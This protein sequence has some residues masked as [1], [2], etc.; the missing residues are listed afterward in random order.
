MK[1]SGLHVLI[2]A[3]ALLSACG[4]DS[5]LPEATGKASISAIN[6]IY[7]SPA[8]DFLIEE[9][10]LA[11]VSYKGTH[12]V[13][14]YDD[15][16]Y[17]FNFDV[18]YA[19]DTQVTRVASQNLDLVA[20]QHYT[21]LASGALAAPTI[22]V[23]ET[24]ERTFDGTET[25]FQVRFAHTSDS[26]GAIDVYYALD[27]VVPVLGE[28]VGTLSFGEITAPMDFETESYVITMTTS[29]DPTDV[30]FQSAPALIFART[31]L[32]ITPFDG[33]ANDTSPIAVRGLNTGGG[34]IGFLDPLYPSTVEF[35]HAANDMGITDV[36]D[37]E[38]LT[39]QILTA[40]DFK[41][42]TPATPITAGDYRY[43]Y[44]PSGDTAT[45]L[46]DTAFS[47]LNGIH[48]RILATG[49]GGTYATANIPL[50]RRSVETAAKL[51][52]FSASNNYQFIDLYV[53]EVGET[54]ENT[55]PFRAG[56][57]SRQPTTSTQMVAGSFDLYL[58]EFAETDLIAGPFPLDVALGDVIAMIV[59]DTAV[60]DVL[61]FELLPVPGSVPIT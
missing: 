8:I 27:G 32:I 60:P 56:I 22:T 24:A 36:Y 46:L 26:L 51:N 57:S 50:N 9:R 15:L 2:L 31:D 5:S 17:T 38:A 58:T 14:S 59:Y 45:V 3:S 33:D 40:H 37:D 47:A 20:G 23:W 35:L 43:L 12:A 1:Q 21:L 42:L 10:P 16:N 44:T 55:L 19:G 53:V 30:L 29:G 52:F 39:S 6:A 54:I 34:G 41:D 7:G 11:S 48:Y 18:F 61:E 4:S 28:E 49:S 13:A 25:V